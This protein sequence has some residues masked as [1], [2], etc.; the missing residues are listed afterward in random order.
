MRTI[1]ITLA[2]KKKKKGKPKSNRSAFMKALMTAFAKAEPEVI[3]DAFVAKDLENFQSKFQKVVDALI[4]QATPEDQ[5]E[6]EKDQASV[7]AKVI[8]PFI[9]GRTL[10]SKLP[11]ETL[12]F[13]A[14]DRKTPQAALDLVAK[15]KKIEARNK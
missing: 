3:S 8:R 15:V 5:K 2:S 11:K 4:A 10:P 14:E 6:D 9:V 13:F 7:T 1:Q 12:A